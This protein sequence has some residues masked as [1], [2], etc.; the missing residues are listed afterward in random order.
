MRRILNALGF[1]FVIVFISSLLV[2]C[3]GFDEQLLYN[4]AGRLHDKGQVKE[5]I[6]IYK[7]LL[8]SDIHDR[9]NP[10]NA[11]LMYDLGVAYI[12]IGERRK[13][14]DLVVQLQQMQREDLADEL[15]KLLKVSDMMQ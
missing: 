5:A 9:I 4:K 6:R 10:D 7:K 14:A 13:T 3:E 2:S 15:Q 11:I 12:D 8:E 1:L